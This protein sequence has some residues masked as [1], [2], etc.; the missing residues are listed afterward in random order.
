MQPLLNTVDV[1]TAISEESTQE[2]SYVTATDHTQS[3]DGYESDLDQLSVT[4]AFEIGDLDSWEQ[5][6]T[7]STTST[8]VEK[9]KHVGVESICTAV[10][11][12]AV[13]E[14]PT[15][16]DTWSVT[17][18]S[19]GKRDSGSRSDCGEDSESME[20]ALP[21]QFATVRRKVRF[22]LD[23]PETEFY[24]RTA[25]PCCSN[26]NTLIC[27]DRKKDLPV[28]YY[29]LMDMNNRAVDYAPRKVNVPSQYHVE[30][31]QDFHA[32]DSELN[33]RPSSCNINPNLFMAPVES[34]YCEENLIE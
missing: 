5:A 34:F 20:T 12:F 11:R 33:I 27:E 9:S 15:N 24:L 29:Q 1:M 7:A 30:G 23:D 2:N 3:L 21:G 6:T 18:S 25:A 31:M 19:T 10:E 28:S 17:L 13:Q 16:D 14:M 22:D 8:A 32:F 4:T 26:V